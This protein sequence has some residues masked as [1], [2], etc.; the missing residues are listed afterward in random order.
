[1]GDYRIET[2]D[3][4]ARVVKKQE[5]ELFRVFKVR[6]SIGTIISKPL[7][8]ERID[9][10]SFR[11]EGGEETVVVKDES[12]YFEAPNVPEELIDEIVI[13]QSLQSVNIAF[14]G[15]GNGV[16]VTGTRPFMLTS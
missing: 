10:I 13:E 12:A 11:K 9:K 2:Q 15:M 16:L 3:G 1:M 14:Q 6:K 4:D 7:K 8:N 5:I